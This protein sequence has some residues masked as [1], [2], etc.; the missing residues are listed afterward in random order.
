M[1]KVLTAEKSF[2]PK[3]ALAQVLLIQAP[4]V[5]V[6]LVL[7]PLADNKLNYK[8]YGN[9]LKQASYCVLIR[10]LFFNK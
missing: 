5:Q 9:H 1:T 3:M 10:Y 2:L 7:K 6:L 8:Q 4:L